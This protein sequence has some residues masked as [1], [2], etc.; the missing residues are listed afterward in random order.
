MELEVVWPAIPADKTKIT[1][2]HNLV[3]VIG[4]Y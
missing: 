3:Q 2:G 1:I 4:N